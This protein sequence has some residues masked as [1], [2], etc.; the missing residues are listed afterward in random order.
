MAKNTIRRL[1]SSIMGIG[2]NKIRFDPE[3]MPRI[4]EA[5]TRDDVRGLIGEGIIYALPLRGVSR[6]GAR[7]RAT[8]KR[9]GRLS[10]HGNRKGTFKARS[11]SKA[12]WMAKVRSQRKALRQL[13]ADGHIEQTSAR[14]IYTMI[15]GNAFRGKAVLM[16]YLKENKHLS[17]AGMASVDKPKTF[18]APVKPAHASKPAGNKPKESAANKPANASK[19]KESAAKPTHVDKPKQ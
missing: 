18:T 2:E 3:Q 13:R 9:K 1:A 12:A 19:P 4:N 17:E 7:A 11:D 6:A 15:K 5:L 8:Q 16:T 10:G 14:K